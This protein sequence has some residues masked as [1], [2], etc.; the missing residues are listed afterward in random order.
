KRPGLAFQAASIHRGE[1]DQVGALRTQ[2]IL[3][4]AEVHIKADD[5]R[6]PAKIRL[7][8]RAGFAGSDSRLHLPDSR[9]HLMVAAHNPSVAI[10]QHRAVIEPSLHLFIA[11]PDQIETMLPGHPAEGVERTARL[12][13]GIRDRRGYT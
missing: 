4:L 6:D 5:H 12:R 8:H 7:K 11:R 10:Y 2:F 1:D 9:E 3:D 13:L